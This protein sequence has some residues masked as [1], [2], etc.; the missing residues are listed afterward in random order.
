MTSLHNDHDD[1]AAN[2]VYSIVKLLF[3]YTKFRHLTSHNVCFIEI[4]SFT[5]LHDCIINVNSCFI[6][7]LIRFW[8]VKMYSFC[9]SVLYKVI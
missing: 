7:S 2:T 6:I 3:S 4:I 8:C 1:I 5:W 9:V